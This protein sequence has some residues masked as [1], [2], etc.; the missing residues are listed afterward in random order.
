MA[1]S[2]AGFAFGCIDIGWFF[3]TIRTSLPYVFVICPMVAST[4]AQYG[5]WKSDHSTMV[6]FA[7]AGPFAGELPTGILNRSTL[8]SGRAAD[9][10]WVIVL[11]FDFNRSPTNTPTASVTS[12]A[13]MD[14][15]LLMV[16]LY[17][18]WS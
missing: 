11:S 3:Q 1:S 12:M 14:V 17:L 13:M 8:L 7:C 15:P 2:A 9:E 18:A 6:T 10:T 16:H 5:H 4:R